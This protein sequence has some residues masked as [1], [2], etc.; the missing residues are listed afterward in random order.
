VASTIT[1][2]EALWRAGVILQDVSP[3]FVR[4]PESELVTWLDDAQ[5]ALF[6]FLPSSGSRVDVIKLK[7]GTRQSIESIA[8]ADCKPGDGSTPA[9]AILGLQLLDLVRNMGADGLTPGKSIRPVPRQI[10][11]DQTPTWHQILGPVVT[12]FTYDPSTPRYFY[13]SPGV[14]AA[15]SVWVEAAYTAQ[16]ARIPNTGAAGAELYKFD[17]AS[18]VKLSVADEFIEDVVNYTVARAYMKNA[19]YAGNDG[20]AGTFASLFL[21]SLNAKVAAQTGSNPNLKFLPFAPEPLGTAR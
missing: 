8:A 17:G 14:P 1:V 9:A 13:V 19:Q 6:K 11:D 5:L 18:T 10:M 21:N 7:P 3:Q 15:T 20:K 4:H 12:Q 16:P 2:K